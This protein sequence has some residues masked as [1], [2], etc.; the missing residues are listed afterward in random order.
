MKLQAQWKLCVACYKPVARVGTAR[1]ERVLRVG[2][3]QH[4]VNHL[5]QDREPGEHG[6]PKPTLGMLMAVLGIV[7]GDI[8]TSP[9]YAFKASLQL[10]HGLPI[11]EVEIMGSAQIKQ[12]VIQKLGF[13]RLYPNQAADF[14]RAGPDDGVQ[15]VDRRFLPV[16]LGQLMCLDHRL[17]LAS[18][19]RTVPGCLRPQR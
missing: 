7:Y 8:G 15:P 2:P 18:G 6:R 17:L 9:L 1:P 13:A 16:P 10:F 3:A 19:R 5:S 11:T 14:A 4:E 12:R